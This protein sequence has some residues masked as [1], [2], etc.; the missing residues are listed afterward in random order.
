M[1]WWPIILALLVVGALAGLL[2]GLLG[3]GGGIV[4]VPAVYL[5]LQSLGASLSTAMLVAIGTSL[6]T[7]I[8]TSISSSRAHYFQ[9][10]VDLAL[11]KRWV[12]P[13]LVGVLMGSYLA[14]KIGGVALTAVF[15]IFA[16]LIALN[17]L[18]RSSSA[19][20]LASIPNRVGQS[21]VSATIGFFSVIMGIGGGALGVPAMTS[22]GLSAHRAIGT[23]AVFGLIISLPGA[24]ILLANAGT[25]ADA[26]L[27][28]VGLVNIPAVILLISM[29]TLFAPIGVKL[30]ARLDGSVLKK[31]FALFLVLA[32]SRMIWQ[33]F[34]PVG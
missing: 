29:S 7:I 8:P 20:P 17:I 16:I 1:E 31:L 4:I 27:G 3:I 11:L 34:T 24:L 9:G 10:N 13:M 30:G 22:F 12:L 26:P 23:A 15:G 19:T 6:M 14:T 33:T 21:L 2:A 18:L 32:G 5:I 25:P 28:T